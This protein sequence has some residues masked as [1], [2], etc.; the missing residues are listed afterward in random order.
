VNDGATDPER[1]S[2]SQ[3]GFH[4]IV[5]AIETGS[6]LGELLAL[7]WTDVDLDRRELRIRGEA[8]KDEE[9]R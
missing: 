4:L 5:A 2:R 8:A 6:R 3:T 1:P 9:L 7:I